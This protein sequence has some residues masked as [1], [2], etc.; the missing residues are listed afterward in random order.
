MIL[1]VIT[2]NNFLCNN[3]FDPLRLLLKRCIV[4]EQILIEDRKPNFV[5]TL[6]CVDNVT[7][8]VCMNHRFEN[9]C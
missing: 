7:F 6:F 2:L 5:T 8:L 3:Y 9:I 4:F 1:P